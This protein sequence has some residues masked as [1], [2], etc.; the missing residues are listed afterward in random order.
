MNTSHRSF[1]P[2]VASLGLALVGSGCIIGGN[3]GFSGNI[4]VLWSFN[5]QSCVF[6]PQVTS[7]RVNIPGAALENNGIYPCLVNNTAGITLLNFRGGTYQVTVEGLDAAGRVI[8][9]GSTSVLVNGDVAASVNLTPTQGATGSALISWVFPNNLACAQIGDV[10]G[11]RPVSRMLISID[12]ATPTAIDCARGNATAANPSAA[13][14]I[15]NLTGGIAHTVDLLAQDSSGFTYLR[16][17][18]SVTVNPGG[19]IA[20]QFQMQWIVGSLPMRWSF[21]NNGV[22][23]TCGQAQVASV[24]VNARNTQTQRYVFVDGAGN[25]TAGQQVPCV[26]ANSLQGTFFPYFEAGNY[27]IYV[28]AP[29]AGNAYTYQS[30]R[31]GVIP[32]L[33]VQAGVFA[34]SEAMGQELVLQ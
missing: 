28:Q 6:V 8:Y 26:S 7:V 30:G 2:V 9:Q 13:V 27:E 14:V 17:T 4:T 1:L 10:G 19:S 24:F 34:Q 22:T 20:G 12:N 29:V 23:I 16:A 25:P 33:Q 3:Q 21:L 32:V 5:G 31:T 15:D 18:N 11:G